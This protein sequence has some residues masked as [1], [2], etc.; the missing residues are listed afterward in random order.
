VGAQAAAV[1]GRARLALLLVLAGC[2]TAPRPDGGAPRAEARSR[3]GVEEIATLIGS[4]VSERTAWA[5]AVLDAVVGNGLESD[6]PTVCAVLAIV[7][8]ESGFHEDPVVPGLAKVVGARI[9]R[10]QEKLGP[11]G[12]PVFRRLLGGHAPT[13][14]RPFDDRLRKVRT[15]RDLDLVFRDL[16]AYHRSSHPLAFDAAQ[17]AGKLF[18]VESLAELNPITT[19]GPMQVSVHFAETWARDHHGEP[20]TVRDALYT[21]VGG[22]YYGTARLFGHRAGYEKMIFR[23]ADYNAGVYTSRNAALQAQLG[24]LVGTSLALDGDVLA[25][26]KDGTTRDDDTRTLEALVRFSARY[27]PTLSAEKVRADARLEKTFAFEGTETYQAVK[28]VF[29]ARTGAAPEYAVLP[30]VVLESPKMRR[31]L[32]TAWFAEGVDRR[33]RECLGVAAGL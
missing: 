28:R 3:L 15:E 30:E 32:S 25:Y 11:L 2:G 1:T 23:F 22:V 21:K 5:R 10:Y 9:E 26:D 13:D 18:D 14:P 6:P 19:A 31:K 24:R 7:A 33:F 17:L 8:Q 27:A 4:R 16:L 20:A 29:A 12:K